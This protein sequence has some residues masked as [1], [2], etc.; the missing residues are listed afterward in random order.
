MPFLTVHLT[1]KPLLQIRC[2]GLDPTGLDEIEDRVMTNLKLYDKIDA[3][4]VYKIIVSGA[5]L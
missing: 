4:K 2:M 1:K 3:D 5:I